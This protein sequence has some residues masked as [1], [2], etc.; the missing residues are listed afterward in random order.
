MIEPETKTETIELTPD[1]IRTLMLD[2]IVGTGWSESSQ[3][4]MG[5]IKEIPKEVDFNNSK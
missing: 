3:K 4:I 1:D 5:F 2:I